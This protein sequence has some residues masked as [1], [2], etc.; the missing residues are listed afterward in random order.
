MVIFPVYDKISFVNTGRNHGQ[1]GYS[2]DFRHFRAL[3]KGLL[4]SYLKGRAVG[5]PA[6]AQNVSP[7]IDDG[8]FHSGFYQVV[9]DF[10]GDEALGDGA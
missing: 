9:F 3:C 6:H 1:V 7:K 8:A 10:V 5:A 4:Q 2:Q